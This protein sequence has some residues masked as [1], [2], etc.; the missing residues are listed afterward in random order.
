MR[1]GDWMHTFTGKRFYLIDPRPEEVSM[2][3]I[4]HAL[5]QLCRFT[6]HTRRFY[7]VAEHCCRMYDQTDGW[8]TPLRDWALMHDAAEAYVGDMNRPLK[9]GCGPVG[10]RFREVEE[11]I[12]RAVAERFGLPWPMSDE[13]DRLDARMLVTEGEQV[14]D[15]VPEWLEEG[16]WSHVD[17]FRV[18]V[19]F[20]SPTEAEKQFLHRAQEQ[21]L[22]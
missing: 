6:G 2:T 14:F 7:S 3:D 20:W 10:D 18:T 9:R 8:D 4:A 21:G 5:S 11:N 13:I 17:R 22:R 16:I 1:R 19:Q 15:P 12:L